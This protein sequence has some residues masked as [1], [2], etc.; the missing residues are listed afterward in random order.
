M[1]IPEVG[2]LFKQLVDSLRFLIERWRVKAEHFV[3]GNV[4]Q[5]ALADLIASGVR[6]GRYEDVGISLQFNDLSN[7]FDDRGSLSGS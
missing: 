7:G 3:N 1:T 5:E 2:N 4:F 6:T